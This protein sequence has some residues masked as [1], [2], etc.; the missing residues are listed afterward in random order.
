MRDEQQYREYVSA[1][2]PALRRTAYLMCGNWH[3]AEDAVQAVLIK[4]YVRP[5]HSWEA[6][7]AWVR[8]SLARRVIDQ[9]RR[10]W[11]RDILVDRHKDTAA[12]SSIPYEDRQALLD[13][14]QQLPARQRAV[15]VLRYWDA[16]TVSETAD[17]LG[18]SEGTVKSHASRGL[19]TLRTVLEGSTP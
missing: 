9:S 10:P 11:R 6:V 1:R 15:V 16:L 3:E 4:L 5:P 7:D 14:L 19:A 8:K 12:A 18:L 17:A 2:T 13:A